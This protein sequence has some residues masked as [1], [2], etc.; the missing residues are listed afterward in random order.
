MNDNKILLLGLGLLF[1]SIKN[2]KAISNFV[3]PVDGKITSAFGERSNPLTG[4]KDFHNGIDI[5]APV[6][7]NVHAPLS[8]QVAKIYSNEVGGLQM[9]LKHPNDIYTGYAHLSQTIA[10]P[11]QYISAG[12]IIAKTGQSGEVTGP[13]LHFTV[14]NS[15]GTFLNPTDFINIPI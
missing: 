1:L 7:T 3:T 14:F 5:A 12:D 6:G 8:G 10:K 4:G 9:I 15:K 11:L 13:H 2:S